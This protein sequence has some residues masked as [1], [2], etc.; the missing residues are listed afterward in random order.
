MPTWSQCLAAMVLLALTGFSLVIVSGYWRFVTL[1]LAFVALIL[2][3]CRK[4]G[5]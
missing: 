2:W 4:A 1:L 3:L 5:S